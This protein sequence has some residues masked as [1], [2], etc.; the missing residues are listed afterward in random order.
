MTYIIRNSLSPPSNSGWRLLPS[1]AATHSFEDV[2][3]Y[4]GKQ[5]P[6]DVKLLRDYATKLANNLLS[7]HRYGDSP[8]HSLHNM[9]LEGVA[10]TGKTFDIEAQ[11]LALAARALGVVISNAIVTEADRL[12]S[13]FNTLLAD[14]ATDT[15]S[16][17]EVKQKI[18]ESISAAKAAKIHS[19]YVCTV[20]VMHPSTAY[21]EMVVGLRPDASTTKGLQRFTWTTGRIVDAILKAQDALRTHALSN[22]TADNLT[23]HIL[24]LDEINRCNLPSVLG[25]LM[26]TVDP[27]RRL[28]VRSYKK[29]FGSFSSD[30]DVA[31]CESRGMGAY[32]PHLEKAVGTLRS[33]HKD[34][35]NGLLWI[36]ENLYILGTMNSSD[37]SILGFDQALRRRFP[38]YRL[39]P[40]EITN[41]TAVLT[42]LPVELEKSIKAWSS[43]NVLLRLVLGA[44]AM[45]GHSYWF[46]AFA[47]G[48][49]QEACHRAWRFGVLPQ[50]IHSAES[51]RQETFV[52]HLFGASSGND[53]EQ[54]E[55]IEEH[56]RSR[57]NAE[58]DWEAVTQACGRSEAFADAKKLLPLIGAMKGA[59][60]VRLVGSGQGA[61]LVVTDK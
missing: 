28:T 20:C 9:V 34:L 61:K 51:S 47:N 15:K 46:Q 26:L 16:L 37:R 56:I 17:E 50:A 60:T 10:G 35:A 54:G 22:E 6:C 13:G 2:L 49:S 31:L 30:A 14:F 7:Q 23:P 45:I 3:Q 42:P 21:E 25:E 59:G 18:A 29:D 57:E 33:S 43:L 27:S 8:L 19:F 55:F 36:P 48:G 5:Y 40:L 38:P 58:S 32:V 41:L 4:A 52:A 12:S 44:D 39:E 11:C 24:V 1:N 53:K